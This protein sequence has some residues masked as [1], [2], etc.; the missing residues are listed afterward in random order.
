[1]RRDPCPPT[2]A[3]DIDPCTNGE[4]AHCTIRPPEWWKSLLNEISGRHTGIQWEV[5]ISHRREGSEEIIEE[6]LGNAH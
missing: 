1:M 4:N 5:W 6:K 2:D 3:A